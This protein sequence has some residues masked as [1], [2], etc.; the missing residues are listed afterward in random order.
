MR[1]VEPPPLL[2]RPL[3]G[4]RLSRPTIF[5]RSAL[6]SALVSALASALV[7][8]YVPP[9][10]GDL[11]RGDLVRGDLDG[12]AVEMRGGRCAHTA[13]PRSGTVRTLVEL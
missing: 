9:G 5:L 8:S 10:V 11:M 12:A 7:A 2:V 6:R 4:P 13:P 1:G 3:R